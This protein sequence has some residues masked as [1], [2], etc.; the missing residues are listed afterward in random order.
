MSGSYLDLSIYLSIYLYRYIFYLYPYLSI[1]LS[2]YLCIY[3]GVGVYE[4]STIALEI[5]GLPAKHRQVVGLL[6]AF[7]SG[8]ISVFGSQDLGSWGFGVRFAS[9]FG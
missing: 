5:A 4:K 2:I 6:R 1:H 9:G 8:F 3:S 7:G